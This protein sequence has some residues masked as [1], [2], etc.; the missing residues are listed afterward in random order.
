MLPMAQLKR[1][2]QDA[3]D[4]LRTV[5]DVRE[6]EVFISSNGNLMARVN[7]TSHLPSNG[8]EEPKSLESHGVGLRIAFED[9]AGLN[10]A[11]LKTGFGSEP[12]DLSLEGVRSA[13]EKAR[14]GAVHD[15]EFVSLPQ[16][17]PGEQR[18]LHR[19]HDP[20]VM[21]MRDNALVDIGWT[22]VEGALEAFLASEDLIAMAGSPEKVRELGL[23]LGGDVTVLQER[24]AIGSTHFRQVQ[25]DESTIILSFLTAMVESQFAKGTGWSTDISLADYSS[26]SGAEAAHNAIASIGGQRVPD[27]QYRV[28][29]GRQAVTDLFHH[30]ILPGLSLDLFYAGASPFQSKLTRQVASELLTVYDDGAAPGLTGSK[31]ITCEGLPTGRTTLIANGRLQGLLANY[32]ESQR[33]LRDANGQTKL[34]VTPTEHQDALVPRNGFRYGHGGGRHFDASP[35]IGATNLVI[36]GRNEQS[37]EELLCLVGD[38]L[39]IGR[40]WYTYPI[41]GIAAGD[42]TCTVVG[43][44]YLVKDGQLA[45]PLKPNTI[46][47]NDSIHNVL[48]NVLGVTAER[49]GTIVWAADQIIYAPE[50][51]VSNVT[52]KEIAGYMEGL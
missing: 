30:L 20:Q 16:T 11:G 10:S 39:Y 21:R 7:Y 46:R 43:D 40:I 49:K 52:V 34:G 28:V 12:S 36:E 26:G 15:P 9:P 48:N 4:Y 19:Y 3:L 23:I 44:S 24:M 42:F 41:N 47:I 18:K 51:A 35:G 1:A 27:G 50:I 37:Q 13:L 17:V 8:V 14:R 31:G 33:M 38:G 22:S 2:T 32:Y 5:P 29:F 25:T 6:A 45:A